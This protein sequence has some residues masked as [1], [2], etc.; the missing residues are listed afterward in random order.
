MAASPRRIAELVAALCLSALGGER[1][2]SIEAGAKQVGRFAKIEFTIRTEVLADNPYDPGETDIQIEL[3]NPGGK[4]LTHPAFWHQPIEREQRPH[5]GNKAEWLYPAGMPGWKARFAP[6]E[7]GKWS[8]AA[9]L[10][11]RGLS[12]RSNPITFECVPSPSKGF[13]RVAARDPRFLEFDD[14][15]PYFPVGQNVAFITDTYKSIEMLRKLSENGA[16]FVRIRFAIHI[17][18]ATVRERFPP[19]TGRSVTVA[20]RQAPGAGFPPSCRCPTTTASIP[21]TAAS[22]SAATPTPASPSPP[23]AASGRTQGSPLPPPAV[24][25]GES[26]IRPPVGMARSNTG[27]GF[28]LEL[29]GSKEPVLLKGGKQWTEFQHDFTTGEDQWWLPGLA[30]RSISKCTM[31]LKDLS[32]KEAAGG[33]E[34]LWEADANRPLIGCYNQLDCAM[35]DQ[36]VESAEPLGLYLQLT[37][38]TRDHYMR[39]LRKEQSR[40]YDRAIEFSKRLLRYAIA[41]WGYS[42]HVFAWE[43]TNEQDPG[44]PTDR[45]YTELG[46]FLEQTD[47]YHHLR[48]NSTW[49][50][51]SK[52]YKHPKLDT[53]DMHWYMTPRSGDLFK[54]AALG[55]LSRVKAARE[56]APNKPVLF[57]EFGL[58]DDKV[59]RAPEI[60][61]DK[62]F[63]HL[64]NAL[65]ASALSGMSSTVCPWWWDDI[66]KL[67]QYRHY[68][69]VSAFVAGIPCYRAATVTERPVRGGNRSLTVAARM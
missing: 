33:P 14:G 12:V 67:D 57:S 5:G 11:A 20:A 37:L 30:F 51:P 58:A 3:T 54:D 34:L 22:A 10:K 61:K 38:I 18:A 44:L 47:V 2:L 35:L 41:R 4:K 48:A 36:L 43:Y 63:V 62:E 68:K 31:Y 27:A 19:R 8:C 39:L 56:A 52:D 64:H 42:T 29:G 1:Q 45:L 9:T 15:S 25:R 66:H 49:H 59:M 28:M 13:V 32:L 69:P 17:R 60:E 21:T 24:G 7:V 26:C 50:C 53:A 46:E 65:W 6:V 16:N 55:V 23:P 40:D